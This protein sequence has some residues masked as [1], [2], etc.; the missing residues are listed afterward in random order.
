[1]SLEIQVVQ[2]CNLHSIQDSNINQENCFVM[3]EC[4]NLEVVI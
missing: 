2:V 3:D 4:L 1:M